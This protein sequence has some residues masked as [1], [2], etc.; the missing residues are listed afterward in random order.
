M[1]FT[2]V[3][4]IIE[5]VVSSADGVTFRKL[6]AAETSTITPKFENGKLDLR[7]LGLP[8]GTYKI[9]IT[10]LAEGLEESNAAGVICIID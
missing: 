3:K 8:N 6:S 7:S 2:L 4:L 5:E 1:G 9:T 10:A